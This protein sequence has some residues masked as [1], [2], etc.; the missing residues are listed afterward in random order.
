MMHSISSQDLFNAKV[1]ALQDFHIPV[2]VFD[3]DMLRIVWAN[4]EALQFWEAETDAALYERDMGSEMS[5]SVRNRLNQIR[6]DCQQ[7]SK[8]FSENWTVYPKGKPQ[9]AEVVLSIIKLACGRDALIVHMLFEDHESS[10]ETLHSAQ[11]LM[12][13]SAM[14]SLYDRN[15]QLVYSNPAARAVA[16]TEGQSL[17]A[18]L[19]HQQDLDIIQKQLD[20]GGECMVETEVV[21]NQGVVWHSM[22]IQLSPDPTT[23]EKSILVSATDVTERR[24]AQQKAYVLAYSDSLTGLSNRIALLEQLKR[25]CNNPTAKFSVFFLDLDRFK[26]VNDSLGH[27]IGD[28]LLVQVAQRM[29]TAVAHR[30]A[31]VSRLG[32]DEFVVVLDG[33]N[34]RDGSE[35]V[36]AEILFALEKPFNIEGHL[37]RIMPSIGI[38]QYPQDADNSTSIMQRAD[39]AMYAAKASNNAYCFY[40]SAMNQ[41]N[42]D[43][44]ALENDLIVALDQK[45]FEVYYQPRMCAHTDTVMGMEAL[46]RW[47]HPE[48]GMVNP[49]DFIS[50]AEETGLIC[51]IGEWV[52]VEAMQQQKVWQAMGF[53]ICVSINISPVQFNAGSLIDIVTNSIESSGCNSDKI[54]LEITESM[55]LGDANIVFETLNTL[56]DNGVHLAIDDFGTGYSNLAYLQKYPL[57]VL[58]I[59]RAFLANMKQTAILEMILRTGKVL[60]LTVVAEGVETIDQINWLKKH[61]CDELQGFFFSKPLPVEQ[62]TE[63]MQNFTPSFATDKAA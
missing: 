6:N 23:G 31:V 63:F 10:S 62:A 35:D 14:I 4:T 22:S 7:N 26:L 40:H 49:G 34:D 46:I 52:M 20:K 50:I 33:I 5:S 58:K 43:R 30:K 12:H 36:A 21:T 3:V 48:R 19:K 1:E 41:N 51:K 13:T 18:L 29:K 24:N 9:T 38:C 47:V 15:Y 11:A 61:E 2:W 8:S 32:G 37:M 60:G 28:S 44:L 53:D 59:D 17:G 54:E 57:S 25:L 45:Q 27:T 55:L 39:L 56:T 42:A 16:V